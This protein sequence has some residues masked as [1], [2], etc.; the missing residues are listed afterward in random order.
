MSCRTECRRVIY[1]FTVSV[2]YGTVARQP[3]FSARLASILI[4]HCFHRYRFYRHGDRG[5]VCDPLALR[6]TVDSTTSTTTTITTTTFTITITTSTTAIAITI[7]TTTA[8][9]ATVRH[10]AA[11]YH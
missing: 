1:I 6:F 8:A 9:N 4:N 3:P 11:T 7:I 5:G 2:D 10:R